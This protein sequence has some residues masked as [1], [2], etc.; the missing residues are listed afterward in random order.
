MSSHDKE[1]EEEAEKYLVSL[2]AGQEGPGAGC[3]WL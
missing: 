1:E 2:E 3:T